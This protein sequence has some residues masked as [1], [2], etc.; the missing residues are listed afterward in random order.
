MK[1][2]IILVLTI[3]C[4]LVYGQCYLDRHNTSLSDAWLSCDIKE[5]PNKDRIPGHW[6]LYDLGDKYNI[7]EV[8]LWNINTPGETE[9]GIRDFFVDYSDNGI[10]WETTTRHNL[11]MSQGTSIYEGEIVTSLEDVT[12]RYILISAI[13]NHGGACTGFAEIRIEN[14]GLSSAIANN[15]IPIDFTTTPNP[16]T[17]YTSIRLDLGSPLTGYISVTDANGK[18]LKTVPC[19]NKSQMTYRLVTENWSCGQ[20][21]AT[22]HTENSVESISFIVIR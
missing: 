12:T 16:A 22:Y 15:D 21:T 18:I 19:E 20:Y 6:I 10:D 14:K 8:T 11:N 7:G 4:Q 13:N 3:S 17:D 9:N 1:T 5:S 2:I